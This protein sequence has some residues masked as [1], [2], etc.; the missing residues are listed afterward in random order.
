MNFIIFSDAST[1]GYG[2]CTYLRAVSTTGKIHC[3][4][5]MGKSRVAPTKVTTIPRLE[6]SA[7]VVAVRISDLLKKDLEVNCIHEFFWTD[8][9][10]VIGYINNDARRFH[11]FVANWVQRIKQSTVSAQWRYVASEDNPADH[12]SRGLAALKLKT[13]NW[14]TGPAFLWKEELPFKDV[15][16]GEVLSADPEL[17]QVF[18]HDTKA[19]EER[20]L[21][22]HLHNFSEWSRLVR[23]LA[24][25]QA[26]S[27]AS[28]R[29][30]ATFKWFLSFAWKER[31]RIEHHKNGQRSQPFTR[32][33]VSET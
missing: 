24:R 17:K 13:S 31:S 1:A 8:C 5:V 21:L 16:V 25:S 20:S 4:L 6:L 18:V 14:F 23:A 29:P 15:M 10:V 27:K 11:V 19:K 28:Q 30:S 32:P 33:P 3:F 26:Q 9:K 7:A 2:V 22:D 12:A